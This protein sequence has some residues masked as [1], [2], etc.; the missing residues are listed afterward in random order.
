MQKIRTFVAVK[1]DGL[2]YIEEWMSY[3][4]EIFR[5]DK[6]KWNPEGLWHLTFKFI[7]DVSPEELGWLRNSLRNGLSG[8]S[9]G[10]VIFRGSGFFGKREA[11]KVIWAGVQVTNWLLALKNKVEEAASGLDLPADDR[12]FRPHLTLGRVKF[13]RNPSFLIE[14]VEKEADT[15]WG[16]KRVDEVILYKSRLT[17]QGPVYSEIECFKLESTPNS[18]P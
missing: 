14:K 10:E 15:F 8:F 1:V 17:S 3:L 9:S 18:D 16:K 13:L 12:P 2:S 4:K 7:G 6:V 5:E 11:P